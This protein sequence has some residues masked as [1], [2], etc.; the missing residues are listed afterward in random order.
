[1]KHGGIVQIFINGVN[2][3]RPIQ[4]NRQN[5]LI[6]ISENYHKKSIILARKSFFA[7]S[8]RYETSGLIGACETF[9]MSITKWRAHAGMSQ[10]AEYC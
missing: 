10:P 6:R 7:Q 1:M 9:N 5:Q 3:R 8:R 4:T 2:K